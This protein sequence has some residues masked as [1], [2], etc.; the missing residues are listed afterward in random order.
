MAKQIIREDYIADVTSGMSK[1]EIAAKYEIPVGVAA[2]FTKD[3]GLKFKR[4]V[5]PKYVLVSESST[6]EA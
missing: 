4:A 6:V 1:A 5:E 3:L 2:K